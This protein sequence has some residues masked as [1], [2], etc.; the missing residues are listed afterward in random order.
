MLLTDEEVESIAGTV[1]LNSVMTAFNGIIGKFARAV[2]AAYEAKLREQE[3]TLYV[4][5]RDYQY[6]VENNRQTA[7]GVWRG[8]DGAKCN[9]P[10]AVPMFFFEHPAPIPE[11]WQLV[12][13]EPTEAMMNVHDSLLMQGVT[14]GRNIIYKA[15]LAAAG[16]GE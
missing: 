4:D 16:S 6:H 9:T 5:A 1:G 14:R 11:G 15:M 3:P 8:S 7:F 13:V 2:I 10:N 12:P